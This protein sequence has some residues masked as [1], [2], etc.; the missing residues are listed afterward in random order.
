MQEITLTNPSLG[1]LQV[2]EDDLIGIFAPHDPRAGLDD[3]DI[4]EK[5]RDPVSGA[6]IS[7]RAREARNV[8]IVTDDK[9]RPTPVKRILP[10]VLE[11]LA[12][13]GVRDDCISVLIGLGTHRPMSRGEILDKFGAAV[14]SRIAIFNHTWQDEDTLVRL[15]RTQS[16]LEV[17]INRRVVDADFIM[18]LGN[19]I[20]HATAG[21][22]G[23][24]KVVMP[25][26]CGEA[27]IADTHW[28]ALDYGMRDILGVLEN[29]IRS[30]IREVCRQVGLAFIVD[31]VMVG[32]RLVDVVAGDPEEAH[33]AGVE[34]SREFYGVRVGETADIVVAEAFP[35]DID[36]RQA[37][38]AVCSAD[39]VVRD[40]GVII[41]AADCPEGISPQFP[42]FE[43]RGFGNPDGLYLDVE[44]GRFPNKLLAYT[45]VAIGRIISGRVRGILVSPHIDEAVTRRLG[46]VPAKD[47]N[48]ALE[49]AREFTGPGR[50]AVLRNAGELL[51]IT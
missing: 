40:N 25:G 23:G 48:D 18:A 4:L 24:G 36:L 5:I 39:L 37:I 12:R 45:L 6:G 41:L 33:R 9:T 47:L 29:P 20:P 7:V 44:E 35:T 38:K 1:S 3:A 51:P 43:T 15:G 34:R 14:A 13:A 28:K 31:S 22:S 10:F 42:E 50:V 11:E 8:L 46:F 16:G 2:A 21:F 17:V 19:I 32:D 27:T 30:A 49:K 26:I